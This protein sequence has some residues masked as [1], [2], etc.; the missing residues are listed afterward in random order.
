MKNDKILSVKCVTSEN[1]YIL[2]DGTE[3][4]HDKISPEYIGKERYL[5]LLRLNDKYIR[6]REI[7]IPKVE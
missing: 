3:L 1:S 6:L 7:D 5:L 2:E 4:S